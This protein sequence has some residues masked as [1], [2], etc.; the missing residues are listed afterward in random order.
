MIQT[1]CTVGKKKR[2]SIQSL[3]KEG[4]R[5]SWKVFVAPRKSRM[6]AAN[7]VI[8]VTLPVFL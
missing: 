6:F 4:S 7:V 8:Y 5:L 1:A 2:C 3:A